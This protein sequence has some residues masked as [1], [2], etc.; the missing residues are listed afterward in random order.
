MAYLLQLYQTTCII[1]P[2]ELE[3]H[4]YLHTK[5]FLTDDLFDDNDEDEEDDD[6]GEEVVQKS[7]KRL[8][9]NKK[10]KRKHKRKKENDG[11]E[12]FFENEADED[13]D[14]DI[15]DDIKGEIN[16][17]ERKKIWDNYEASRKKR[18]DT[19]YL[20]ALEDEEQILEY[21]EGLDARHNNEARVEDEADEAKSVFPTPADPILWLVK[22]KQGSEREACICL[23]NKFLFLKKQGKPLST[24]S[25]TVS[26]KVQGHL[27]I[28][29]FK[30][31]HVR[32]AI[33]GLN[34][35][36]QRDVIRIKNEE[37][38]NVFEIDKASKI[39]MNKGQWVK[40][41]SGFYAGDFAKVIGVDDSKAGCYLKC[42]PRLKIGNTE[43]NMRPIDRKKALARPTRAPLKFFKKEEVSGVKEVYSNLYKRTMQ[44]WNKNYY[45]RGFLYKYFNLK[46]LDTENV[47]P[48]RKILE[49]FLKPEDRDD[50][51]NSDEDPQDELEKWKKLASESI[52]L[53]KGDKIKV[54]SGDLKNLTGTVV[55]IN[56]RVI[57][58][59]P[60]IE[61]IKDNLDLDIKM[62][63]KN[64]DTGDHV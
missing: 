39:T 30:E 32:A 2:I 33:K 48:P 64:F 9:K 35:I 57:E 45:Y 38:P 22:C 10:S 25:A 7:K 14:E 28:E 36:Y 50:A 49:K 4:S 23:M 6:Y 26:D 34:L 37:T 18:H 40:I 46:S 8:K 61:D 20:N 52:S 43:E 21:A 62:I 16:E 5:P 59:K 1:S 56:K 31:V 17:E 44:Y 63:S 55:T 29:A 13:E 41:N 42:I 11:A 3:P 15:E 27:Y 51:E 53:T 58:M 54:I 47:V 24:I 60:D 19:N 12:R